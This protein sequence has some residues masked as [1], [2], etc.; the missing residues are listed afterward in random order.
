MMNRIM[1]VVPVYNEVLRFKTSY[2]KEILE[3]DQI[4]VLFVND[5]SNDTT[6]SLLEEACSDLNLGR[7]IDAATILDLPVNSGKSRA[8]QLGFQHALS[9]S[10]TSI[11]TLA[12]LDADGA[13]SAREVREKLKSCKDST[14]SG[15]Y[16]L[17]EANYHW[18]S[19][20]ALSGSEI[21]RSLKRHYINR[22]LMTLLLFG[23]SNAPYDCQSGFKIFPCCVHTNKV[24]SKR[25]ETRWLFDIEIYFRT[26][27]NQKEFF[28]Q[29]HGIH[30]F[31]I[32]FWEEVSGSKITFREQV[33]MLFEIIAILKAKKNVSKH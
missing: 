14:C 26:Q 2:W 16:E 23:M 6:L 13:F 8:V 28:K 1:I 27:A 30:E 33:R 9:E 32:K 31:P 7:K 17:C 12:F 10:L 22:I 11:S 18:S 29:G 21:K 19:R 15:S 3:D 24:W 25:F 5:G 4:S 20:V